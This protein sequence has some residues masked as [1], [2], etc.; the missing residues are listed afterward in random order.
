MWSPPLQFNWLWSQIF[1][2]YVLILASS[3]ITCVS[4]DS[5]SPVRLKET[6]APS[7]SVWLQ[8]WSGSAFFG[9][10]L[11]FSFSPPLH[12]PNW[13]KCHF[14]I[15]LAFALLTFIFFLKWIL[16]NFRRQISLNPPYLLCK[17]FISI[18]WAS[19]VEVHFRWTTK[20]WPSGLGLGLRGFSLLRSRVQFPHASNSC[21]RCCVLIGLS[22]L[23]CPLVIY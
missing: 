4:L 17:K 1:R 23:F 18:F 16:L 22:S 7:V 13:L 3:V 12:L 5:L 15:T 20:G 11:L 8:D 9:P 6:S 2:Q 19:Q 21:V 10:N 14:H